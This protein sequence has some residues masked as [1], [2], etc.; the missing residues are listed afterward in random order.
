LKN[1]LQEARIPSWQRERMPLLYLNDELVWAPGI[2]V[3]SNFQAHGRERALV[4]SWIDPKLAPT[5]R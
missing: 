4:F 3:D 2:G 1:L 5:T